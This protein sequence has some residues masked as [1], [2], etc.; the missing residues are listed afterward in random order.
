MLVLA[1]K[2][3]ETIRIG[4]DI[5]IVV[6]AIRGTSVRLGITAPKSVRIDR[7]EVYE[8]RVSATEKDSSPERLGRSEAEQESQS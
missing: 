8:R 2:E 4:D 1:R 7:Q 3:N 5:E 6:V